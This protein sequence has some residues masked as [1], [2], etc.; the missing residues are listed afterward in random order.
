M[1]FHYILAN[2]LANNDRAVGALFLD[3][4]GETIDLACSEFTPYEMRVLGAYLGIQLRQIDRLLQAN[5]LGEP[6]LLHIDQENL[7]IYA[8][9]LPDAYY[10]VLVQRPPA[11]VAET[12]RQLARAAE[13][14]Q[15]ELFPK[16]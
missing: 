8:A 13:L 2:L 15:V 6:K 5:W 7:Q 1:P 4:S 12:R 3:P 14:I 11:R 9:T 16:R 10:L